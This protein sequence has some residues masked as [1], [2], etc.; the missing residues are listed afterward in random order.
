MQ[1]KVWVS[2]EQYDNENDDNTYDVLLPKRLGTFDTI[3]E[4]ENLVSTLGG[5]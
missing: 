2:I 3:E 1:F 4:A 5:E